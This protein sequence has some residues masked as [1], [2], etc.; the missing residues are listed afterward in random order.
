[1][2]RQTATAGPGPPVRLLVADGDPSLRRVLHLALQARGY[3]VTLAD[4]ANA[5]LQLAGHQH[6]E[7][8]ILDLSLPGVVDAI[9]ALRQAA[10]T[11]ILLLTRPTEPDRQAA[12]DAGAHD[13]LLKPF[14]MGQLLH[15]LQALRTP[16]HSP[17]SQDK[18]HAT[19]G[20]APWTPS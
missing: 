8:I 2:S 19:G 6:P 14:G 12:L 20:A 7:L 5:A 3:Q 10:A 9:H 13:T 16:T 4:T 11:S 1:M 15:H 18:E 17:P